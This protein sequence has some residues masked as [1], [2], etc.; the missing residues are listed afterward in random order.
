[1]DDSERKS[2]AL[3]LWGLMGTAEEDLAKFRRQ[4]IGKASKLDLD[5]LKRLQSIL[6]ALAEALR[7][8]DVGRWKRVQRAWSALQAA[9]DTPRETETKPAFEPPEPQPKPG[10]EPPELQPKPRAE[11]PAPAPAPVRS[12]D[13][14]DT[15]SLPDVSMPVRPAVD[16]DEHTALASPTDAPDPK[17]ALPF[18]APSPHERRPGPPLVEPPDPEDPESETIRLRAHVLPFKGT[19]RPAPDGE[20]QRSPKREA[21]FGDPPSPP[22]SEPTRV[23]PAKTKAVEEVSDEATDVSAMAKTRERQTPATR[24]GS[25]GLPVLHDDDDDDGDD[26]RPTQVRA[27]PVSL[28]VDRYARFCAECS[29]RSDGIAEVRAQHGVL[30][31]AE[32]QRLDQG[33]QVRFAA[34]PVL[35][36]KW[37]ILVNVHSEKLLKGK[38]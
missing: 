1:M 3:L 23:S 19:P 38:G 22:P 8:D 12:P 5:H 35:R 25:H 6:S 37:K 4:R 32:H 29:V 18:V 15:G 26:H 34:N 2:A 13:L 9:S 36:E 11:P 27:A 33:W 30:D 31:E 17:T 7:A 28:R 14:D 10:V 16:L 20:P 24:R 21:R